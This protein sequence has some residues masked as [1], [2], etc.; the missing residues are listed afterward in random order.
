M[1]QLISGRD[2]ISVGEKKHL[3]SDSETDFVNIWFDNVPDGF[4]A[5]VCEKKY[6]GE[7]IEVMSSNVYVKLEYSYDESVPNGRE[8]N[9][10]ADDPSGDLILEIRG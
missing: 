1:V 10:K 8:L 5:Y 4:T 7:K 9:I 2:N 3:D 6:V